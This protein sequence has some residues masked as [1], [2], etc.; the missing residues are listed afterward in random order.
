LTASVNKSFESA[1]DAVGKDSDENRLK[2]AMAALGVLL[3]D[4]LGFG[5]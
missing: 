2:K 5:D 1:T 4:V 3:V